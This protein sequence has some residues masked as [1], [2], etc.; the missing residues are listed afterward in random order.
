MSNGMKTVAFILLAAMALVTSLGWM[1]SWKAG[2]LKDQ[3]LI[4]Y[5]LEAK[6]AIAEAKQKTKITN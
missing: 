1:F 6:Q 2:K 4:K 5:Q 3:V